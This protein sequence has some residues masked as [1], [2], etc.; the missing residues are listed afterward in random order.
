MS[1]RTTRQS[2]FCDCLHPFAHL[3]LMAYFEIAEKYVSI[4]SPDGL[5]L[6][7]SYINKDTRRIVRDT[8]LH[9][10]GDTR[11]HFFASAD[12]PGWY[13]LAMF[14]AYRQIFGCTCAEG[15]EYQRTKQPC[16][17]IQQIMTAAL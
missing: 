14:D 8:T 11:L 10:R 4:S 7:A 3:L 1:M 6:R 2:R 9:F 16:E 12:F 15:K 13:H 17:H 5:A